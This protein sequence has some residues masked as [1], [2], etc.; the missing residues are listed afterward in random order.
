MYT[1]RQTFLCLNMSSKPAPSPEILRS[2]EGA[3]IEHYSWLIRWALQLTKNDR[4]RAEDLVQ[5]VFAQLAFRQTN[6]SCVN[7]IPAYLYTALRNIHASEMRLAGRS[8]RQLPSIVEYNLATTAL[9][10]CNPHVLY[11]TQDQLRRICYY[12]CVRKDSSRAGS[13]MILRF[14]LGYHLSEVALVLGGSYQA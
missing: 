3:F 4:A 7:N 13:V 9:S 2:Q 5:E 6:L 1:E 12:A 10:A 8:H 11:Q 14:F